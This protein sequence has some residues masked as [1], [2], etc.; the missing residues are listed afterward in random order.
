VSVTSHQR[1][2][3]GFMLLGVLAGTSNGVAKV[4]LPLYAASLHAAP[5][6]IGLVGGLQFSGMLLLSMPVGGLID[7]HGSRPLFR[8]GGLA[9][10]ALF[11]L[12]FTQ[13]QQPTQL[14]VGVICFG[15]LNP[16]RMVATQT[17]FLHLLPRIGPRKAGWQRA[18]HS[19]GMFFIGPMLG[20]QLL[21]VRSQRK[22][23][24]AAGAHPARGRPRVALQ[25]DRRL[26]PVGLPARRPCP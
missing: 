9:G 1:Y 7:R 6:Q 19:L 15:L 4:V 20:A 13:M 5:W 25:P 23:R 17:E 12:G 3:L 14:I 8:F 10:A 26:R 24:T 22:V 16:F 11:L 18:S 21:T 2:L